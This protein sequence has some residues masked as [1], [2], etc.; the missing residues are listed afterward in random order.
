MHDHYSMYASFFTCELDRVDAATMETMRQSRHLV[1]YHSSK[2]WVPKLGTWGLTAMLILYYTI[3][4][5]KP[6]RWWEKLLVG[7]WKW[8]GKC[9]TL[10][11]GHSWRD[12]RFCVKEGDS[13][14][15]QS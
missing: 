5:G 3:G 14:A 11:V 4:N 13:R 2:G 9:V 15:K 6:P 8:V 10:H 1:G 7:P 12:G